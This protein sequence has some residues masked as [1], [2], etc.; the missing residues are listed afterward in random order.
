MFDLPAIYDPDNPNSTTT[1]SQWV[2][3][4]HQTL[5]HLQQAPIPSDAQMRRAVEPVVID[6]RTEFDWVLE[7]VDRFMDQDPSAGGVT[8]P[9]EASSVSLDD[10]IQAGTDDRVAFPR[11][12]GEELIGRVLRLFDSPADL[13]QSVKE[14]IHIV[15][16]A[17]WR[18]GWAQ[19]STY[20]YEQFT[21]AEGE[22][23]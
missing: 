16:L 1:F 14:A 2:H 8:T 10:V 4:V 7:A 3:N 9:H 17:F 11:D 22:P 5:I 15:S 21:G 13:S 19:G 20:A 6:L 18:Q 12:A 23:V